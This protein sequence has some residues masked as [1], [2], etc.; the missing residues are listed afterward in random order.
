M[1]AADTRISNGY[2]ILSR[3]QSKTTQLTSK[4]VITSAGMVADVETLHKN[5]LFDIKQYKMANKGREPSV[6]ALASKLSNFLYGRRFM[7]YYAFNLLCGLD[8]DGKGA[9]FGYDAVGSYDKLT[10]G[11]QG[12]GNSLGAPILDNQFVGHNFLVKVLPKDVQE[13]ENTAKDIINSIAERDIYTGD[14]VEIV[15]VTK[16]GVTV[17]REAVRRD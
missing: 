12:S 17:K 14:G 7:P 8:K 6:E 3:K 13:T 4:C 15:T 11:V 9:V 1:A 16:D 2:S 10:Y 5:L